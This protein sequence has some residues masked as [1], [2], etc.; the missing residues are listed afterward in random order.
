MI[1]CNVISERAA[2]SLCN[3]DVSYTRISVFAGLAPSGSVEVGL[4]DPDELIVPVEIAEAH[5]ERY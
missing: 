5:R 3:N 1:A 4:D 2:N